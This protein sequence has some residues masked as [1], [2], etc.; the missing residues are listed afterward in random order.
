MYR[1]V[2]IRLLV[3][4]FLLG[5]N[6]CREARRVDVSVMGGEGQGGEGQGG[7]GQGGEGVR[8][9]QSLKPT[10]KRK[11]YRQI[12]AD[13]SAALELDSTEICSELGSF[14]CLKVVHRL[15]LGG[16]SPDKQSLYSPT[17]LSSV[18]APIALERVVYSACGTRVTR[19]FENAANAKIFK[20]VS[21]TNEGGLSDVNSE[22]VRS[23]VQTLFRRALLREPTE[24]EVADLISLYNDI[25]GEANSQLAGPSWAWVTCLA[26][27][28]S[29]EFVFY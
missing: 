7:E 20:N 12:G 4:L 27:F 23:A 17:K 18:S 1:P 25:T 5:F 19:D 14:D 9:I 11:D 2:Q 8:P 16:I 15:S 24:T 29:V 6:A 22:S 21:L 3:I 10:L 13:L 26:L 28:T